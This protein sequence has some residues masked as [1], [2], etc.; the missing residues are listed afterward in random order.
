MRSSGSV[1]GS[2]FSVPT[3]WTNQLSLKF[4]AGFLLPFVTLIM[5]NQHN[6][7]VTKEGQ[8]M[9]KNDKYFLKGVIKRKPEA[10]LWLSLAVYPPLHG[11]VFLHLEPRM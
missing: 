7:L 3:F 11:E 10:N 8:K 2:L 6:V 9:T 4:M 1:M 5:P